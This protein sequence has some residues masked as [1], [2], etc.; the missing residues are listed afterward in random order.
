MTR[1]Y[2]LHF[3][4]FLIIATMLIVASPHGQ[5]VEGFRAGAL[6]T[7]SFKLRLVMKFSRT[8][9]GKLKGSPASSEFQNCRL[10]ECRAR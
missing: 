7:G 3:V 2:S 8:P 4:A 6:D 9:D 10:G 1:K 5:G